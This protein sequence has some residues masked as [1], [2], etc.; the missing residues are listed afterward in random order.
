MAAK[1]Y[2]C[3]N[4]IVNNDFINCAGVCAQTFHTKCVS[5][6]KAMLNAVNSCPNIYWYCHDCNDDNRHISAA[7][8]NIEDSITRLT[9][10]LSGDLLN[11]LD[12]L[13]TLMDNVL[14]KAVTMGCASSAH[15][16]VS[17]GANQSQNDNHVAVPVRQTSAADFKIDSFPST[18][19]DRA[20]TKSIVVS[21]IGTDVTVDCLK[22]YICTKLEIGKTD[23][24]LSLLLPVGRTPDD[25]QFLQYKVTIPESNYSSI[26]SPDL[27][28]QD[29]RLRDFVYK[30]RKHAGVSK[31]SFSC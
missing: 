25:M 30:K 29:V 6:T 16:I 1:C 18:M 11:F 2:S 27:W 3:S 7:I 23:V 5:I 19:T 28:P 4:A 8:K 9:M 13:K 22:N 31:D 17:N 21:N 20:P 12:G 26:M 15:S 14:G 24:H 10:S